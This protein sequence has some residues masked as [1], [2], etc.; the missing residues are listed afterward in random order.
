VNPYRVA[1]EGVVSGRGEGDSAGVIHLRGRAA[2]AKFALNLWLGTI[3]SI[4]PSPGSRRPW[5]GGT[6]RSLTRP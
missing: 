2:G 1:R 3:P 4:S 6:R 5:A